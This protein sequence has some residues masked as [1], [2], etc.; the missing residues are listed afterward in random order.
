M[1]A[2]MELMGLIGSMRRM[3]LMVPI[4]FHDQKPPCALPDYEI[5]RKTS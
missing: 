5:L 3:G 1:L 4:H 2:V